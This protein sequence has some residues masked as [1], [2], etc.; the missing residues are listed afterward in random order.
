MR[1]AAGAV[2]VAR[3]VMLF[4]LLTPSRLALPIA[5][6]LFLILSIAPA[7]AREPI[8]PKGVH[9]FFV[10]AN[11]AN[12]RLAA[13]ATATFAFLVWNGPSAESDTVCTQEIKTSPPDT[14]LTCAPLWQGY[15]VRRT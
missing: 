6:G 9:G 7:Q 5:L 10:Q 13:N 11:A 1:R 12:R 4:K 15:R 8:S 14:V 2:A 3:E